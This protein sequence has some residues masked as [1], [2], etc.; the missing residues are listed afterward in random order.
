MAGV[1]AGALALRAEALR[2]QRQAGPPAP[3]QAKPAGQTGTLTRQGTIPKG[4]LDPSM[5]QGKG[6][7]TKSPLLMPQE[8]AG[9][10][11][12]TAPKMWHRFPLPTTCHFFGPSYPPAPQ[13]HLEPAML[14]ED[15]WEPMEVMEGLVGGPARRE[16]GAWGTMTHPDVHVPLPSVYEGGSAHVPWAARAGVGTADAPA[17]GCG[18]HPPPIQPLA[19]STLDAPLEQFCFSQP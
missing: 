19:P 2:A 17:L 9:D 5:L 4:Q 1:V 18:W 6:W 13:P 7:S 8:L 12:P 16:R 14:S 11:G 10:T 3:A 15:F